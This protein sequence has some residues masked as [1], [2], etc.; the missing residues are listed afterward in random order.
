[1]FHMPA[2]LCK[3]SLDMRHASAVCCAHIIVSLEKKRQLSPPST[4]FNS[5]W[6]NRHLLPWKEA[7]CTV[8][9]LHGS[10]WVGVDG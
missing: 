4:T 5:R 7:P 6:A 2:F 3:T 10:T 9:D 8:H 1:M